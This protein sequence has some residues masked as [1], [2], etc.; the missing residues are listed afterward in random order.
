MISYPH[1]LAIAEAA[2]GAAVWASL[3]AE[4]GLLQARGAY[5]VL[6]TNL[7]FE[8]CVRIAAVIGFVGM[9]LGVN[10]AGLGL[11]A[12]LLIGTEQARRAVG[13]TAH[14][15]APAVASAPAYPGYPGYPG[16]TD[17]FATTG[18]IPVISIRTRPSLRKNTLAALGAL[19]P[20]ALLQ[21][22]DVVIVGWLNPPG[23]GAYAAIATACKV[24]VFI[25]M[26]VA[27]FLLPEAARRLRHGMPTRGVLT[28]ALLFVVTPG[29]LFTAAGMVSAESL[30]TLVFGAHLSAG[31]P[32]MWVLSLAMTFLAVTLM[33]TTYLLGAGVHTVIC[34]LAAG[35]VITVFGLVVAGGGL[36]ATAT[37]GLACQAATATL[38]GALVLLLHRRAALHP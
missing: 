4:R 35:T 29:L 27:N 13:R 6:A 7:A 18:P 19:V 9:G 23:A 30:L 32:A 12:G 37:A 31:A 14:R 38:V 36:L 2:V 34:A 24:P 17:P 25:G 3:S 33:L 11:V 26:A 8:S 21:N 28:M 1:P 15:P 16:E 22:M 20:L 5:G 10:G